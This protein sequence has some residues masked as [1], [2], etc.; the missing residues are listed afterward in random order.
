[1]DA[2]QRPTPLKLPKNGYG[3]QQLYQLR[4]LTMQSLMD[5]VHEAVGWVHPN[6]HTEGVDLWMV[7]IGPHPHELFQKNWCG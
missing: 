7:S 4:F 2:F 6:T 5:C 1:M 3:L